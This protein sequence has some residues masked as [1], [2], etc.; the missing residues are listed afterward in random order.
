MSVDLETLVKQITYR[1]KDRLVLFRALELPEQS[2]TMTLLSPYVQ[3]AIL[4]Q[5]EIDEIVPVLD[6]M[7]LRKAE[8]VVRQISNTKL[9]NR[10]VTRLKQEIKDKI[11]HFLRFHPKATMSLVHFNYLLVSQELTIGEVADEIDE[12]HQETGKFPEVLVH[13]RGDLIGE[14]P[15]ATLVRERNSNKVKNFVVPV[16]AVSYMVDVK[17]VI[18]TFSR[19]EKKEVV[20]LDEDGSVLGIIYADDALSLFGNMPGESLYSMVGLDQAEQPFDAAFS[21][22]RKRSKWLVL[23]LVTAFLAGSVILVFND[24][25]DKLA[26]LAVYIPI[27]AGMG[28]NAASQTFAVMMRGI[29]LGTVSYRDGARA[30]INE[31]IAGAL[32]GALIGVIVAIISVLL[33]GGWW[34]GLVVALAMVAVHMVAGLFGA[35]TPLLLQRLGKDPATTSMILVTTATDVFGFLALLSLGAWLLL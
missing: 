22:F 31:T 35:F 16:T 17:E 25:I 2:A 32:N 6:H 21:K 33:Q 12:H 4:Q 18:E 10:I 29:T 23:N 24:T 20:V 9:R 8:Q 15:L 14:I 13:H 1:P 11:E 34:L 7:D 28:G 26:V 30:V 27:V 19:I 3:Q 5:L